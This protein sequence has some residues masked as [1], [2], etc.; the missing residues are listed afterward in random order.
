ML[1]N[2]WDLVIHIPFSSFFSSAV[3]FWRQI[4]IKKNDF[5][6]SLGAANM[7]AL[8]IFLRE[9]CKWCQEKYKQ[10]LRDIINFPSPLE[11]NLS[12]Y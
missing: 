6:G 7:G 9:N 8:R 4:R 3:W 12:F 1:E 2:Q 5:S 11:K 10:I